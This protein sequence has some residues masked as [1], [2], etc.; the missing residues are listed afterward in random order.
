MAV[1][2]KVAG[3]AQ[4]QVE[5]GKATPAGKLGQ[6]LGPK[7]INIMEFCKAFNAK[8]QK[9]EPGTPVP[10][11]MTIYADRSF[12][13]ITKTP[14]NSYYIKQYA[15]IKKGSS[16]PGRDMI[17]TISASALKEIAAIK[18]E[19]TNANDLDAVVKM[20]EGSARSMGLNVTEG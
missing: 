1:K 11:V 8:T 9:L 6:S 4:L 16:A 10:V 2:K 12:D 13:F 5:A 19:D 15:K 14:P 7:G 3:M 17:G 20:L 18:L